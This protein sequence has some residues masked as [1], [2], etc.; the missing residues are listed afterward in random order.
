[1][2]ITACVDAVVMDRAALAFIAEHGRAAT[3][4]ELAERTGLPVPAAVRAVAFLVGAGLAERHP[5]PE[6][7]LPLRLI[8][9]GR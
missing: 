1:M 4:R 7:V 5:A 9:G 6:S 2:S 8:Q 3:I